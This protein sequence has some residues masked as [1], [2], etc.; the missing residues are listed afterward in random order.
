MG[1]LKLNNRGATL[2]MSLMVF[3]VACILSISMLD[4]STMYNTNKL[5]ENKIKEEEELLDSGIRL[6]DREVKVVGE[7]I[8]GIKSVKSVDL[9]ELIET[10]EL[11][12]RSL[13][14]GG[15]IEAVD[16]EEI[17]DREGFNSIELLILDTIE[18]K[19][20]NELD[21]VLVGDD[22]H[23]GVQLYYEDEQLNVYVYSKFGTNR[24]KLIKYDKD[25]KIIIIE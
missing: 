17:L 6:I 10:D 13:E 15:S 4:N 12:D 11:E 3:M 9:E 24:S 2:V 23:V 14:D 25:F 7:Y 21:V 20:E 5:N 16:S 8:K 18:D 22:R 1:R 19:G